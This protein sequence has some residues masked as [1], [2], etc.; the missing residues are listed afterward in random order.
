MTIPG[1]ENLLNTIE[2]FVFMIRPSGQVIAVNPPAYQL[3]RIISHQKNLIQELFDLK[4][5]DHALDLANSHQ[6]RDT[7][8]V[9][10]NGN[11]KTLRC[12]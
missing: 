11:N 10:S 8:V 5:Y 1:V 7:K 9:F 2:Y 12:E 4:N 6:K 3:L